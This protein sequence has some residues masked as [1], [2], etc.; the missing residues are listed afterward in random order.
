MSRYCLISLQTFFFNWAL[1]TLDSRAYESKKQAF[2]FL[3][4]YFNAMADC[5]FF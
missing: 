4:G 5:K 2:I 3:L 1:F